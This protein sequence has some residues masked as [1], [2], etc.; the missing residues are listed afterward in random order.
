M[1]EFYTGMSEVL[2]VDAG[3]I[4]PNFD[5]ATVAWDSL[6]I[7]STIALVDDC[8]GVLLN[9]QALANCAT[10]ADIEKLISAEKV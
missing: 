2:E 9:G 3:T 1:N 4:V 6:A 8:F 5:L 7:V 10:I